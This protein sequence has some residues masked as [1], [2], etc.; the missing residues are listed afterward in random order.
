MGG[1]DFTAPVG[2]TRRAVVPEAT[3]DA[4]F[5][6]GIVQNRFVEIGDDGRRQSR[7]V[8]GLLQRGGPRGIRQRLIEIRAR[9]TVGLQG[10]GAVFA[11]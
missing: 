3:Y 7:D 8:P 11:R 5:V 6:T 10:D 9:Q 2:K 4:D 1:V